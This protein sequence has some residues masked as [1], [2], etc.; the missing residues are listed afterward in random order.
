MQLR[1]GVIACSHISHDLPPWLLVSMGGRSSQCPGPSSTLKSL[2]PCYQRCHKCRVWFQGLFVLMVF[3]AF[4]KQMCAIG[5]LLEPK[6]GWRNYEGIKL[7][8]ALAPAAKENCL[9][10]PNYLKKDKRLIYNG[11]GALP[12]VLK[13]YIG[14]WL[15]QPTSQLQNNTSS[16]SVALTWGCCR[17]YL[18]EECPQHHGHKGDPWMT[19]KT[20]RL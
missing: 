8:G 3:Q 15:W 6:I 19:P 5:R 20:H 14:R 18:H 4:F 17:T 12:K 7:L 1:V 2:G 9:C 13:A 16:I 11:V 10:G